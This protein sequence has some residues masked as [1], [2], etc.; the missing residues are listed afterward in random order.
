M[1]CW[2]DY[3]DGCGKLPRIVGVKQSIRCHIL[4]DSQLGNS[5][6]SEFHRQVGMKYLPAYEGGTV[7]SETSAYNIKTPGN[8]PEES[9]QNSELG[10]SLKLR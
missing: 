9:I 6:A 3:A 8:Y 2:L 1:L 4:E 10:E 5:P 7:C